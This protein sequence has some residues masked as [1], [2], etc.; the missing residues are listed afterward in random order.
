MNRTIFLA[1]L[2][3]LIT[4]SYAQQGAIIK[5]SEI[6]ETI[7]GRKFYIHLVQENQNLQTISK[8]Y[9]VS[10]DE[11]ILFN[12]FVKE[13]LQGSQVLQIPVVQIPPA[14]AGTQVPQATKGQ[15]A[16]QVIPV[17]IQDK[18]ETHLVQ[19]GETIYAITK[20]YQISSDELLR[21]N[22]ALKDGLKS[23][24]ILRLTGIQ[25]STQKQYIITNDTTITFVFHRVGRKETLYGI[26]RI[27]N[28]SIQDINKFNPQAKTGIRP[29]QVL[30]IP[31][32]H[33]TQKQVEKIVDPLPANEKEQKNTGN[34][35]LA[36]ECNNLAAASQHYKVAIMLPLYLDEIKKT[37]EYSENIS[38][39]D[40]PSRRYGFMQYYLGTQLALD[41]L[42]KAGLKARIYFYDVDQSASS[43]EAVLRKPELKEMNLIIGPVFSQSF[44]RIARFASANKIKIVNPFSGRGDFL[45]N[46]PYAFKVLPDLKFEPPVL[47]G[48]ISRNFSKDN[49]VIVKQSSVADDRIFE[50]LKMNL[51]TTRINQVNCQ[52]GCIAAI[53]QKLVPGKDNILVVLSDD[54]V[55]V[56]ELM[57]NLNDL[58][59]SYSLKCIGTSEWESFEIEAAH[60]VNLQLHLTSPN[61]ID[62]NAEITKRFIKAFRQ[63][64]NIDPVPES[65]AFA[66]FDITFYFL[67]AMM[68]YGADFETCLPHHSASG[69]QI[70]FDFKR[71][72]ENGWENTALRI[73]RVDNYRQVPV[74]PQ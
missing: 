30:K 48:F 45:N 57:R 72:D 65:Y 38:D 41:S 16:D 28:V 67:S 27:Y 8:S 19:P 36:S 70:P 73:Y 61:Y 66:A 56:I 14:E 34:I 21:L 6:I 32:Y 54:K 39:A 10:A 1:I 59:D 9:G 17:S 46:N 44:N 58:K 49:I 2:T 50:I 53:R 63:K 13:G 25:A 23:G 47:A 7:N 62:Y 52:A 35:I 55:F 64:Y 15:V 12:P 37:I 22:P 33:I 18:P 71:T 3:C 43:A 26:G 60:S 69:L 11:I 4:T 40:D 68:K 24:Q 20:R 5:R 74:Y 29:R 31:V 42:E 51:P